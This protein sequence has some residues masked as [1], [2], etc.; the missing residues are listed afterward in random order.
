MNKTGYIR[1]SAEKQET[2]SVQHMA[3]VR[4]L[5]RDRNN[6]ISLSSG[7]GVISTAA[8]YLKY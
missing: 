6:R 1:V 8:F 3:L 4:S 2:A 7:C 5:Q